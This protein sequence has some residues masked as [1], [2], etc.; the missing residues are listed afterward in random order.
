MRANKCKSDVVLVCYVIRNDVTSS[1]AGSRNSSGAEEIVLGDHVWPGISQIDH[2]GFGELIALF[3]F[4]FFSFTGNGNGS[5]YILA[6]R[7]R[8][9]GLQ[10]KGSSTIRDTSVS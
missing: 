6:Y 8:I 1:H 7:V 2:H 5:V 3:F 10:I 9:V 4:L